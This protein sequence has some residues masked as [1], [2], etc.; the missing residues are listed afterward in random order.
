MYF[1]L[2]LLNLNITNFE[3]GLRLVNRFKRENSNNK[4]VTIRKAN[5]SYTKKILVLRSKRI[6]SITAGAAKKWMCQTIVPVI[7]P[8]DVNL[9]PWEW[10]TVCAWKEY[11]LSEG[12]QN[13]NLIWIAVFLSNHTKIAKNSNSHIKK[14]NAGFDRLKVVLD[15]ELELHLFTICHQLQCNYLAHISLF[16]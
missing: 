7:W 3:K 9:L 1:D 11:K 5:D 16:T 15:W 10:A 6:Q 12:A 14:M 2:D 13:C 8:H 4:M